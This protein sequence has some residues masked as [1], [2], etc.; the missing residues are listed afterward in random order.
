MKTNLNYLSVLLIA[1]AS[2]SGCSDSRYATEFYI[3]TNM[4]ERKIGE[5]TV[6]GV[7]DIYS[8]RAM[9][10]KT[11]LTVT[12]VKRGEEK[13]VVFHFGGLSTGDPCLQQPSTTEPCNCNF[14]VMTKAEAA[15]MINVYRALLKK[16][17]NKE[18]DKF[19]GR[20]YQS[21]QF[22]EQIMMSLNSRMLFAKEL[23]LLVCGQKVRID[24]DK[25]FSPLFEFLDERP[26]AAEPAKK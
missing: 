20:L 1:I 18:N 23:D 19:P 17:E 9:A 12:G 22:N 26:A 7:R 16:A 2:F 3:L 10:S 25:L 24:A 14:V 21:V 4:Q 6:I 15:N 13:L 11:V 8:G 5:Y